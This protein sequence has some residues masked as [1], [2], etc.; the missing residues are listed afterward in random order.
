MHP[1]QY[2]C[3]RKLPKDI[4]FNKQEFEVMS[5]KLLLLLL[6]IKDCSVVKGWNVSRMK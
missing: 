2:N 5:D 1:G 6:N 3:F 4:R